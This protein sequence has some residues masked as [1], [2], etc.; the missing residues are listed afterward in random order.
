[1]AGKACKSFVS[2]LYVPTTG[3]TGKYV[4]PHTQLHVGELGRQTSPPNRCRKFEKHAASNRPLTGVLGCS[5]NEIL[6]IQYPGTHQDPSF[7]A[8]FSSSRAHAR[9]LLYASRGTAL[10]LLLSR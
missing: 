9:M 3:I 8:E 5:W 1:M 10:L 2:S 6:G 7:T 4:T